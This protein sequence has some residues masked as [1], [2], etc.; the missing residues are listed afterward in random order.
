MY[1]LEDI[2]IAGLLAMPYGFKDSIAFMDAV[3]TLE[4]YG[5]KNYLELERMIESGNPSFQKP[6]FRIALVNAKKALNKINS[7]NKQGVVYSFRA[8]HDSYFDEIAL[9]SALG[10]VNASRLLLTSPLNGQ[11]TT[12]ERLNKYT[13]LELKELLGLIS[14]DGKN[15]FTSNFGSFGPAKTLKVVEAINFLESQMMRLAASS[16]NYQEDAFLFFKDEDRKR[17]MIRDDI[18]GITTEFL[19]GGS[20]YIFGSLSDNSKESLMEKVMMPTTKKDNMVR[21]KFISM[22][23]DYTITEELEKG[24][25][26]TRALKRFH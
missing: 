14:L 23:A 17:E 6:F 22:I 8:F 19:E 11:R 13:V 4:N 20:E 12:N 16:P 9:N 7:M 24:E 2:S 3:F 10:N 26:R 5:I 21:D 25:A 15:A 1:T 18:L